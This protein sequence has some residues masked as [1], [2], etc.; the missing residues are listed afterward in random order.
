ML[1][2]LQHAFDILKKINISGGKH[3][4]TIKKRKGGKNL[5]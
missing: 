5:S 4:K 1:Q 3:G 2:Y